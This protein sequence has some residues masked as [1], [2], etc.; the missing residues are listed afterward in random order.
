MVVAS[1]TGIP[2]SEPTLC[3]EAL[4]EDEP[5]PRYPRLILFGEV[6]GLHEIAPGIGIPIRRSVQLARR[7]RVR[8]HRDPRL[9]GRVVAAVRERGLRA[10]L[11]LVWRPS[12]VMARH[13]RLG[14]APRKVRRVVRRPGRARAPDD[15]GP[16]SW[17]ARAAGRPA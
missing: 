3:A 12:V 11:R 15:A 7:A 1:V 8:L 6:E 4:G 14:H 5:R 9:W 16:P 17:G 2:Y 10:G 13:R